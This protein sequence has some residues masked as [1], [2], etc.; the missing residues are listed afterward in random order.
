MSFMSDLKSGTRCCNNGDS[1][2]SVIADLFINKCRDEKCTKKLMEL[3]DEHL[4]L[5]NAMRIFRQVELTQSRL[6]TLSEKTGE[7]Q[8]PTTLMYLREIKRTGS[9]KKLKTRTKTRTKPASIPR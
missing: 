7:E 1:E 2:E 5:Y 9:R 3:G 8:V 4:T 6:K